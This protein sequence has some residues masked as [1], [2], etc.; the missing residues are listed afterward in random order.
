[1]KISNLKL[2]FIN[3]GKPAPFGTGWSANYLLVKVYTDEGIYGV[4]EAFHTGKD[5]ATEGA[6]IEYARWLV[7]K[8][9]L[10]GSSN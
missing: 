3:S 4:G 8:D 5:K 9:P 6:L 1:M 10:N 7:G 2:F